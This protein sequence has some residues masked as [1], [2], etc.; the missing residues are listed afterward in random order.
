MK[1]F[2]RTSGKRYRRTKERGDVLLRLSDLGGALCYGSGGFEGGVYEIQEG[3]QEL[4][5]GPKKDSSVLSLLATHARFAEQYRI[6]EWTEAEVEDRIRALEKHA[7]SIA[8]AF[9]T[10]VEQSRRLN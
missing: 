3:L 9:L 4:G 1:D 5:F 10:W 7:R 2:K 8:T 6:A